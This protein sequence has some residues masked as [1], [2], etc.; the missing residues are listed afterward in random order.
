[1]RKKR[2][3]VLGEDVIDSSTTKQFV[4]RVLCSLSVNGITVFRGKACDELQQKTSLRK[5]YQLPSAD[6]PTITRIDVAP[7]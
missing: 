2:G 5:A 3:I 1:V 6:Q 7:T 4:G